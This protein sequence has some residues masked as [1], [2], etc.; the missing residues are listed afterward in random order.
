MSGPHNPL[1]DGELTAYPP[2]NLPPSHSA[3]PLGAPA[4]PP[5]PLQV[6]HAAPTPSV[7]NPPQGGD[8]YAGAIP[9]PPAS[10]NSFAPAQGENL[11][12]AHIPQPPATPN[13]PSPAQGGN[14]YASQLPHPTGFPTQPPTGPYPYP[15]PQLGYAPPA[16]PEPPST[17]RNAF[18][19]MLA[20]AGVTLLSGI[21]F[22]DID[23]IRRNYQIHDMPVSPDAVDAINYVLLAFSLVTLV[24]YAGLW[25]WMAF[26]NRAGHNWARITA[27]VFYGIYVCSTLFTAVSAAVLETD[28]LQP[29]TLIFS[30]AELLIGTAAMVLLWHRDSRSFFTTPRFVPPP[31]YPR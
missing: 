6:P 10:P 2:D 9:Q 8:L 22:A 16:K 15:S 7:P 19:L 5:P 4:L 12:G 17:V 18:K 20:G 23:T 13:A 31:G 29:I 14:P 28:L 3:V 21:Q 30:V 25:T 24:V 26:A 27:T 11:Y 1:T